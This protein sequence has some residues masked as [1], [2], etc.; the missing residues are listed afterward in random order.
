VGFFVADRSI[1]DPVFVNQIVHRGTLPKALK[2]RTIMTITRRQFLTTSSLAVA[3]PSVFP[4]FSMSTDNKEILGKV[5]HRSAS[6]IAIEIISPYQNLTAKLHIPYFSRPYN[7]FDGEYGNATARRLLNNLYEIGQ[8][9][10][11]HML[12]LKRKQNQISN[13]DV[14]SKYHWAF[15]EEKFPMTIPIGT[16]EEVIHI[17]TGRKQLCSS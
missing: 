16:R 13:H 14:N 11:K 9:L 4:L 5:T 15:F 8:H 6:D 1:I 17:L 2:R 10:E 12:A 3:S 7:S